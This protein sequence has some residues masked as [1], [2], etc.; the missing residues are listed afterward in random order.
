MAQLAFSVW[1]LVC[2]SW[3]PVGAGH[4]LGMERYCVFKY[5]VSVSERWNPRN[6]YVIYLGRGCQ[7][8]IHSI[9]HTSG[10][11]KSEIFGIKRFWILSFLRVWYVNSISSCP[12]SHRKLLTDLTKSQG[13]TATKS[14]S[15]T[16]HSWASWLQLQWYAPRLSKF[17]RIIL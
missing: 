15:R 1:A 2:W 13:V 8:Q 3:L 10:T 7:I 16:S 11:Q 9:F 12:M 5:V 14:G 4:V 17:T 6:E